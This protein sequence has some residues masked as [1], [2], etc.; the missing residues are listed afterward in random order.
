VQV[1]R[2]WKRG[3]PKPVSWWKFL[4]AGTPDCHLVKSYKL[5]SAI[6]LLRGIAF[7]I[8]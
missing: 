6:R 3:K 5:D 7:C 1:L 8:L 4:V 2:L